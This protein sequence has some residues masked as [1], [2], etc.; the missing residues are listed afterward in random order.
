[1]IALICYY[2]LA[3]CAT[4]IMSDT[5]GWQEKKSQNIKQP[6]MSV[7]Q[8]ILVE[9]TDCLEIILNTNILIKFP[10]ILPYLGNTLHA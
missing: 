4:T 5:L 8:E 9:S 10:L 2:S 6:R 7:Q 3:K 1:M